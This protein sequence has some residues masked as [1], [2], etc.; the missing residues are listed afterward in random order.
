MATDA[1]ID[2]VF[3]KKRI[4]DSFFNHDYLMFLAVDHK[5]GISLPSPSF[6]EFFG[7]SKEDKIPTLAE[8]THPDDFDHNVEMHQFILETGMLPVH[9]HTFRM[10]TKNGEYKRIQTM[11]SIILNK[12]RDLLV[13]MFPVPEDQE[14]FTTYTKDYL[15]WIS[16][17]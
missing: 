1:I 5:T 8:M 9:F 4:E 3:K 15:Q 10:K 11:E 13:V 6:L 16:K 2:L 7:Y 14:G 12:D 17:K